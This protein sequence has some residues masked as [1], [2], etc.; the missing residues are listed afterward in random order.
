MK[1][2]VQM[3]SSFREPDMSRKRYIVMKGSA[4]SGKSVDTTYCG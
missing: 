3:N 1:I 4:G 2:T